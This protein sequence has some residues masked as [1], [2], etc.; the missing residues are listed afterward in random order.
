MYR[1]KL[2]GVAI[3]AYNESELIE[4]TLGS[5]P[6]YVDII[7]AVDDGSTDDTAEKIV[8]FGDPRVVLIRK[9]N[10]G[11]GSAI[12]AGYKKALEENIDLVAVLAGD[13]QMDP[14][15]LPDLLDPVIDGK[16]DYTKGNRLVNSRY[17]KGMSNWR[18]LGNYLLTFLNKIVSGYWNVSDPQ[19]GYTIISSYA[20][21][22]LNLDEI[23]RGYAFENDM[24]VKLNIYDMNVKSI[25]IPAKYADEKS[26]IHY[27]GFILKTSLYL[28]KALLWRS[29]HKYV[30]KLNPIGIFYLIGSFFIVTGFF[31]LFTLNIMYIA[32]GIA[33]FGIA[34]ILEIMRI[35]ILNAK[36]P[37]EKV[38]AK[39]LQ[40]W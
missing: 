18:S 13:D 4:K 28:I 33:M 22:N 36:L 38:E 2:V 16:A 9:A 32:I 11:V 1:K 20:L 24:L 39:S 23:S 34:S 5:I 40:E 21:K 3:P 26:H 17:R 27:P 30:V 29:W 15:Y 8:N 35:K 6:G 19:N 14:K 12:T 7:Y 25:P 37:E 10:G 31:A